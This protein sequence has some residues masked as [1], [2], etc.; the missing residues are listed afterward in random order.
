MC[1]H[2]EEYVGVELALDYRI[3]VLVISISSW[4]WKAIEELEKVKSNF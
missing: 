4:S 1:V 2:V 3:D